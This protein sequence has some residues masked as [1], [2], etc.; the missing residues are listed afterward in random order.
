MVSGWPLT[1]FT[2]VDSEENILDDSLKS[3]DSLINKTNLYGNIDIQ[4]RHVSV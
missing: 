3:K 4:G 1:T 2:S